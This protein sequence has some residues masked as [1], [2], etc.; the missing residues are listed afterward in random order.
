MSNNKN[1]F[2][3]TC[4][5]ISFNENIDLGCY[6][7]AEIIFELEKLWFLGLF[8]SENND[9]NVKKKKKKKKNKKNNEN[10]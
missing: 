10:I 9:E 8:D 1:Y 4:C 2:I 6:F 7:K 3:Q 5:E